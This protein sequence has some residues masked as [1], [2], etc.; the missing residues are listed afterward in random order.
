MDALPEAMPHTRNERAPNDEIWIVFEGIDRPERVFKNG[1]PLNVHVDRIPRYDT[2]C[3]DADES[4][5][6]SGDA[7]SRRF[8]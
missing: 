2:L 3:L 7:R 8:L 4:L 5:L 6:Q 1:A